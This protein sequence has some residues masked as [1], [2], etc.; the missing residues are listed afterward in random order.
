MKD[1]E[2]VLLV[3]DDP[4]SSFLNDDLLIDFGFTKHT[5]TAQ[6][7]A[8]AL[9]FLNSN[10]KNGKGTDY[11]CPDVV[12]LDLNMPVMDGFEF[13]DAYF[14]NSKKCNQDSKVI[15][16]T[17]ST[18]PDDIERAK[19]YDIAGYMNKPLSLEQLLVVLS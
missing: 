2:C 10:C 6:N 7:G 14:K 18:N 15:V 9:E 19:K 16:L 12:F 1:L 4:V 11:C 17:S 13:M 8:E 5:H 3:D